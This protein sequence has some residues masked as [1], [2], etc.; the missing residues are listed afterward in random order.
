[1]KLNQDCHELISSLIFLFLCLI[2]RPYPYDS[3]ITSDLQHCLCWRSD[4]EP[5]YVSISFICSLLLKAAIAALERLP[6]TTNFLTHSRRGDRAESH[7]PSQANE[8]GLNC[9]CRSAETIVQFIPRRVWFRP[10]TRQ[11][12]RSWGLYWEQRQLEK[13]GARWQLRI[14]DPYGTWAKQKG[15]GNMGLVVMG[16][17]KSHWKQWEEQLSLSQTKSRNT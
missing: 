14:Q 1:M 6:G 10:A 4:L 5:N 2:V 16:W 9:C 7:P 12:W 17:V 15:D 13:T 11:L 8:K 3:F